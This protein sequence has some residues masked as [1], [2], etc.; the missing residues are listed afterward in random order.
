MLTKPSPLDDPTDEPVPERSRPRRRPRRRP[1][2]ALTTLVG[3]LILFAACGLW[4]LAT[5]KSAA[6][7]ELAHIY[8]AASAARGQLFG[9]N[10]STPTD[11]SLAVQ[12]PATIGRAPGASCLA[13]HP[14]T[15][16][17]C[18]PPW[19]TYSGLVTVPTYVGRYPPLYYVLVGLPSRFIHTGA[20]IY[21]MRLVSAALTALFLAVA[22]V[23]ASRLRRGWLAVAGLAVAITP[24]VFFLGGVVNPSSVEIAAAACL[25]VCG[26]GLVT[27][28]DPERGWLTAWATISACVFVQLRGLSPLLALLVG[29]FLVAFVGWRP[30][31][32]ALRSRAGVAAGAAAIA[33][34]GVFAVIWIFAAG[35]LRLL[36]GQ[37]VPA[38]DSEL[39]ILYQ[40]LRK[41]G[42]ALPQMVG[43]FDQ[44]DTSPPGWI[45]AVWFAI[46]VALAVAVAWRRDRR[47]IFVL[48][49]LT[50]VVVALPTLLSASQAHQDGVVGQ[51]RYI[52][53]LSVGAPLL[54]AYAAS[55]GRR[56]NGAVRIAVLIGFL[57]MAVCQWV[58]FVQALHRNRTGDDAPI[59]VRSAPW[60]PPGGWITLL[61]GFGVIQLLLVLW[62]LRLQPRGRD[63]Q[64][65][66]DPRLPVGGMESRLVG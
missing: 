24:Q 13:G 32:A 16:A 22:F 48:I 7:D 61:V 26:L 34:C 2:T 41:A 12:V 20:V 14:N 60:E 36:P 40:A 43:V 4:S 6:P 10:V 11:P 62:W 57:A 29:C 30:A 66:V 42:L 63:L 44:L 38:G 35:S 49:A 19:R 9:L 52:M 51:A 28:T 64:G 54:A 39:R 55:R 21:A 15:S 65:G 50:V 46:V 23:S 17:A 59:W 37:P 8:R 56:P 33:V 5:P 1:G 47:A 18:E 58:A 45:Y 25:W 31:L 27:N 53:P 3:F